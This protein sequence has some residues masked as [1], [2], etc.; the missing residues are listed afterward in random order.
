MRKNIYSGG[1]KL[2]GISLGL[3]FSSF[4]LLAKGPTQD[5]S[6]TV[7]AFE[8]KHGNLKQAFRI[9]ET[10]TRFFF[11]Y[12][13]EDVIKYSDLNFSSPGISV[14]KLLNTLLSGTNLGYQQLDNNIIV[15][16]TNLLTMSAD[17]QH[18][19]FDAAYT[20][21]IHGKVTNERGEPVGAA[22]VSVE[23]QNKGVAANANGEFSITGLK[24]GT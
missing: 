21:G 17:Q 13:T 8:I 7:I 11:T 20:G 24:T 5:L 3:I 12:K 10:E 9:I 1:L 18:E 6:K 15:K 23:G 2:I 19:N 14:E 16:M 22:S 4:I